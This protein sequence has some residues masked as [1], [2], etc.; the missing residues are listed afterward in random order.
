MSMKARLLELQL[1]I[2]TWLLNAALLLDGIVTVLSVLG[3]QTYDLQ[4]AMTT[5]SSHVTMETGVS[6]ECTICVFSSRFLSMPCRNWSVLSDCSSTLEWGGR[7]ENDQHTKLDSYELRLT[8]HSLLVC[9]K[10]FLTL[11]HVKH[12]HSKYIGTPCK[13]SLYK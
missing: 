9:V 1:P 4:R 8:A 13:K 6:I 12:V 2:H 5:T 11:L 10:E 7:W 3:Q